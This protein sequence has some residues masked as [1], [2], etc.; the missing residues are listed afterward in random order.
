MN[1]IKKFILNDFLITLGNTI[2]TLS[3]MWFIYEE[4]QSAFY[5]AL[6]GSFSHISN[7]LFGYFFGSLADKYNQPKKYMSI[8]LLINSICIF[9]YLFI[10]WITH[11]FNLYYLLFVILLR[12]IVMVAQYPNQTKLIPMI[13]PQNN[14]KKLISYRSISN[15][16]A[17]AVGYAIG[18]LILT[19][20]SMNIIFI[21]ISFLFFIG[22]FIIS[23]IKV[24]TVHP[25]I[26]RN[27][28]SYRFLPTMRYIFNDD[29][30][31]QVFLITCS[32]NIVSMVAP[33]FVVYFM[34][35][36]KSD[37]IQY[38]IFQSFIAIG[39]LLAA[40]VLV[41]YRKNV[42]SY[43]ITM[44]S[45][46]LMASI[47]LMM[48]FNNNQSIMILFGFIIGITLTLPNILYSTFK[49]LIIDDA[50]RGTISSTIK[51]IGVIFI[52]ISYYIS[53]Y[54]ADKL[55]ANYVFLIAGIIQMIIVVIFYL[56]KKTK[57]K[58]D[59]LV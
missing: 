36:L 56:D 57:I 43:Y 19:L 8:T 25:P 30:L 24:K 52:P 18:G 14:V 41:K 22:H 15:R 17:S 28:R 2:F 12:E 38:G 47:F 32:L 27:K 21:F 7:I 42:S 55:G 34:Q 39:S 49:I 29:Y 10:S 6:A 13:A 26:T 5:T 54:I 44:F 3:I 46:I 48:F 58:F 50:Y 35:Y 16:L 9:S 59:E 31:K 37:S 40:T 11:S 20:F 53:A 23:S 4:T 51:S 1:N 45:W 33:N